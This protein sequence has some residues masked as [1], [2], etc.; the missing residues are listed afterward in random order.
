MILLLVLLNLLSIHMLW[1]APNRLETN[2]FTFPLGSGEK[3][4]SGLRLVHLSDLQIDRYGAFEEKVIQ[5][6]NQMNADFIFVT[7]DLI[8]HQQDFEG[9]IRFLNSLQP[10]KA[11]F[12]TFGNSDYTNMESYFEV[13]RKTP[14]KRHLH[15]LRNEIT[16]TFYRGKKIIVAGMDDPITGHDKPE[17]FF[18]L[19]DIPEFKILLT[20]VYLD[21]QDLPLFSSHLI[22]AG[23]THGG[24]INLLPKEWILNLRRY[25]DEKNIKY[26][27]GWHE[28]G[29][30]WVHV[31]RGIG[32]SLFPLRFRSRPEMTLIEFVYK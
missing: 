14:L 13:I 32:Y 16:E 10:K 25:V 15:L 30:H 3:G 4:L 28:E 5:K 21:Y 22:L 23:H 2:V 8:G 29:K 31:S 7:G 17:N 27:E 24:Q 20:H 19:Q 11:V 18:V 1:I 9:A 6:T 26:L 12:F